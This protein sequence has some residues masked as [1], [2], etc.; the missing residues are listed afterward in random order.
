M[1]EAEE[2]S[3]AAWLFHEPYQQLFALGQLR[4]S[5]IDAVLSGH[6]AMI[7]L[8]EAA[9]EHLRLAFQVLARDYPHPVPLAG[10]L[11][12]KEG[13][14]PGGYVDDADARG[15]PGLT[16]CPSNDRET[17]THS[18]RRSCLLL[19]LLP[20]IGCSDEPRVGV[21]DVQQ[22]FQRSPL[23]MVAA[24]QLKGELGATRSDIK[25]RGRA[26]AELLKQV[27]HGDIPRADTHHR[28][29]HEERCDQRERPLEDQE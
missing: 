27:R 13:D 10:R 17:M 14:A 19:A 22:A 26:L 25:K 20:A 4:K 29:G 1:L 8:R 7:E 28:A 6:G 18:I 15:L 23:G 24:L 9:V 16:A 11:A 21:V 5:A 2:K 12:A 3:L